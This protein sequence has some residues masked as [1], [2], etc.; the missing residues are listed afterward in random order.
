MAVKRALVILAIAALAGL[1]ARAFA[2][3]RDV[4]TVATVPVDATAANA[5]AARDEARRDGEQRAYQMLLERLTLDV[6]HTR[7]PA[8]S[9]AQLDDL[10]SGFEVANE[11]TSGVRYLANYTFHFNAGAVRQLLQQANI[12]FCETPSKPLVVLPVYEAGAAPALWEDPNPWRDAWSTKPPPAGLVPLVLPFGD[13][14]D[15]QA[16][17]ADGAL[18]GDPARLQAISSRYGG[19]DVLVADAQLKGEASAHTLVIAATRYA[20]GDGSQQQSVTKTL[21][22]TPAESD[23]DLLAN[24]VAA[25]ADAVEDAWKQANMLDYSHAATITVRVPLNDLAGLVDVRSRL[26]G[27]PA[28]QKSELVALDR[29]QATLR[30]HYVGDPAQLRTALAQHDL[31][32]GG[33][34]PDF[35][36]ERAQSP[37]H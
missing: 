11:R 23:A 27:V 28:I 14:A 1:P 21:T 24:G 15:V 35:V 16:I 13:L 34:D 37:P 5:N 6:D 9:D 17:D 2:A 32:L 10:V 18:K 33:Q 26:D 7:L 12:P 22:A 20:P 31:A 4:Y 29:G 8:A 3:P 36:L 19:A 30:I 25:I